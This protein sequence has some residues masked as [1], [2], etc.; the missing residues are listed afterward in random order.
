MTVVAL[1]GGIAVGKTAMMEYWQSNFSIPIFD[2]DDV[3]RQLLTESEILTEVKN[4]FGS[5]LQ[6]QVGNNISFS[7]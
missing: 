6:F 2:T 4:I 5:I 7:S 1:T 3:G